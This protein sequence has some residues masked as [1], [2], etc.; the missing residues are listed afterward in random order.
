[1]FRKIAFGAVVAMGS[2][3]L[4]APDAKDDVTA[5]AKKLGDASNYSWKTTMASGQFNSQQEGKTEK[6]GFTVLN[7]Q[8]GDNTIQVVMKG[9]K[10]AIKLEDGWKT[11]EELA[12]DDQ[13]PG[14]F[15]GPM[16]AAYKT[17][18]AQ[19]EEMAPKL[20]EVKKDGDVYTS[21]LTGA[22]AAALAPRR[23]RRGGGG[24]Q[25]PQ[26]QNAKLSLKVWVKDGVITKYSQHVTGT[27]NR[28]GDDVDIDMTTTTE[29]SDV[30]STKPDVP[31]DAKKKL[32]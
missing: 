25:A 11:T 14:R 16:I 26:M 5:A 29:I 20:K 21:E 4:A 23:G 3:A 27:V 28:G 31:A 10:A 22:D 24:G 30:G 18:A 9:K 17:P 19:A 8:F 6:D 1:M 2:I 32:E 7:L 15:L 12:G 13:G